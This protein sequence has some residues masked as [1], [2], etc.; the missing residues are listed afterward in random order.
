MAQRIEI[1]GPFRYV[2]VSLLI[3]F[4]AGNWLVPDLLAGLTGS[5]GRS[6]RLLR[7]GHVERYH[8]NLTDH[9]IT[10]ERG[11]YSTGMFPV[12]GGEDVIVEFDVDQTEGS[13]G[14]R[15]IRYHWGFWREHVWS[16]GVR[17]DQAGRFRIPVPETGLYE[18]RL[19]Y[20]AFAGDVAF[21]WSVDG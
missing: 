20:S 1:K 3:L 5:G 9:W 6:W 8:R 12:L 18:L 16:E 14:F 2:L 15:L 4:F 7:S 11:T 13:V 19:S 10:A 21:D 17:K